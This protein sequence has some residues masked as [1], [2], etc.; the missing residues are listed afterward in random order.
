TAMYAS[1]V[2]LL[3]VIKPAWVP[4]LPPE[5][6]TIREDNGHSGLPSLLVLTVVSVGASLFFAHHII[7]V[8]S[9][10]TGEPV[11]SVAKDETIVVSMCVGVALAFVLS[12]V[13][14]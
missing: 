4:A 1:Y 13:N 11:T 6:R 9:W 10:W 3:A 5:A 7:D 14:K 12:M 2:I 8:H